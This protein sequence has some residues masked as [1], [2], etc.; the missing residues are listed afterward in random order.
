MRIAVVLFPGFTALDAVGPSEVLARLPDAEVRFCAAVPGMVPSAD[1]AVQLHAPDSLA[2]DARP[3]VLVV[4]GGP[5]TRTLVNDAR[6]VD[7]IG[8]VHS[9][10]THTLTVCTG[11]LLLGATGA[12]NG[13]EAT[14]HWLWMDALAAYGA[15]AVQRRVV[16]AG[17]IWTT[18][19]VSAGIDGALALA[20][21]LAGPQIAQAIQ[22]SMEYA[23]EPPF[24]AGTPDRAPAEVRALVLERARTG[25]FPSR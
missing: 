4:P 11:S 22:L 8:R 13:L 5:G 6:L 7:W 20:A 12:L 21:R 25:R 15:R 23:P 14:T 2:H 17:K 1:G 16:E 24:D 18:A 10:T 3:E 9:T 19:G